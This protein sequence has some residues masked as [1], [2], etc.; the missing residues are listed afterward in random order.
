MFRTG[1]V[2]VVT[3]A[4]IP[5]IVSVAA[6]A[7]NARDREEWTQLFNG[8]DLKDWIVKIRGYEPG[9]NF[10]NT[11]RVED[12]VIKV[13][14]DQYDGSFNDRFGH[15]FYKTPFSYYRLRVTY[16]FVGEQAPGERD[17]AA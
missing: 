1:K 13:R 9:V 5:I 14:Y 3:L 4:L 2:L 8:R 7:Q 11:F 17:A 10:G 15:L 12:G 16:R 6:G